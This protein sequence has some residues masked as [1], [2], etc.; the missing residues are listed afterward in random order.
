MIETLGS[1]YRQAGHEFPAVQER[2][3]SISSAIPGTGAYESMTWGTPT[4]TGRSVNPNTAMAYS[5]VWCCVNG[6]SKALASV[7]LFTYRNLSP[8]GLT[9][10][11]AT[12]DYRYRL[13]RE[14][15]NPEM[16]SVQWRWNGMAS[17]L[18][19]G[20]WYNY[21]DLDGRGRIKNIWFLRP[22]W[23]IPL[24]NMRTLQM[25]YRYTP[26]YPFMNQVPPGVYHSDQ[27][28]H[29]AGLG[30]DGIVGYSPIAMHRNAVAL[31]QAQEE[32]GGRFIAGGGTQRV[33]LVA[34]NGSKVDE[35]KTKKAWMEANSGL[36]TAGK[37]AIL[38]GGMDV[39]TFGIPPKDA[40][41]LEGR[42]WQLSEF[43]RIYDYP[44]GML[45][46]ALSKTDSYASS[47]Q[48]DLKFVKHCLR[49]WA[50][51]VEAKVN[52]TVLG[53]NDSITCEHDLYD[54]QRGD[55]Q[56]Q[57]NSYKAGVTGMVVKPNEARARLRLPPDT[58]PGANQLWGQGQMM[59][60]GSL[61]KASPKSQQKPATPP[62]AN[63]TAPQ[64]APEPTQK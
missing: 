15:P 1:L 5:A 16:S 13:L 25:E 37:V 51:L 46:D 28:L 42:S 12:E 44:L 10:E 38:T 29:I 21:L 24:R 20:N 60:M 11:L 63:P 49:P 61:R 2:S 33:A 14:Q 50:A 9:R 35:A 58:D 17:L 4:Y 62:Q 8:D 41:Y 7:N 54:L 48:D 57:M 64:P 6:I 32:A 56:S 34:P 22:D 27:I 19:W 45:Y 59:P 53:S 30:Y 47:E 23:I 40:Q 39:K 36:E 31:G 3:E 43:A 18:T 26:L 52:I 55:L